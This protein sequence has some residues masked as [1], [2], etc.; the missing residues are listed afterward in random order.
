MRD[1]EPRSALVGPGVTESVAA[2]ASAALRPGGWLVLEVG[3]GQAP[4]VASLL[5]ELG[6]EA[7]AV[8]DDLAGRGRVVEGRR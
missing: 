7:V 1:W 6:F 4:S 2:A 5:R 3:D 8:T